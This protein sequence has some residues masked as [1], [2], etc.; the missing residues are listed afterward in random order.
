MM[1]KHGQQ[2]SNSIYSLDA[3]NP[4]NTSR[5]QQTDACYTNVI[6]TDTNNFQAHFVSMDSDG[7]TWNAST[8]TVG[9]THVVHALC[10]KGVSS[11]IGAFGKT[12]AAS[13]ATQSVTRVGFTPKA[14]IATTISNS[15]VGTPLTNTYYS[16]GASDGNTNRAVAFFDA[17]ATSPT[18]SKS[19]FYTDAY[20]A[21][22][23]G[24]SGGTTYSKGAISSM[25]TD[26]FTSTFTSSLFDV[27]EEVLYLALGDTGV[28]TTPKSVYVGG[29]SNILTGYPN[30]RKLDRCQNGY[31]IALHNYDGATGVF[32]L[33]TDNGLT[34]DG[35]NVAV[36]NVAGLSSASM[37]VDVDDYIHVA[38]KQS[39]TGGGRTTSLI[40]Y[41]RGTPNASRTAWTWSAAVSAT[42]NVDTNYDNPD[43]I[44]HREGSGWAVHILLTY[45]IGGGGNA[46]YV[47]GSTISAVGTIDTFTLRSQFGTGSTWY[48]G[49]I[50]FNHTGDAKTVAGGTPHLYIAWSANAGGTGN[51]IRFKK[52]TYAAGSWTFGAEREIDNRYYTQNTTFYVN[53]LFDGTRVVIAGMITDGSTNEWMVIHDRDATDTTT[54]ARTVINPNGDPDGAFQGSVS[55]DS[56]GNIYLVGRGEGGTGTSLN[57][58]KWTRASGVLTR[59]PIGAVGGAS[60][61]PYVSMKRGYSNNKIEWL[62]T[63]GNNIPY[64]IKYDNLSLGLFGL[65]IKKVKGVTELYREK[66]R[67]RGY[68]V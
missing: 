30:Q 51:G 37:F 40:Y 42:N 46:C 34:W 66:M 67:A 33:S 13:P 8:N 44:A 48:S 60:S 16:W 50:D 4:T 27:N 61:N 49:S 1:N 68:S 63:D 56:A 9:A 21:P 47:W 12:N 6:S 26:G 52:A 23:L 58:Y 53:C 5:M 17:D 65:F 55:Y 10:L 39:G 62:Y 28:N 18:Q 7:F 59:T 22:R 45:A 64:S 35:G 11:K 14:I 24:A 43:I 32:E 36:P 31:M 2:A 20:I 41:M 19:N 15:T 54:T 29:Q 38:W 25:D 3:V 57:L